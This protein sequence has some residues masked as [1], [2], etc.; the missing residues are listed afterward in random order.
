MNDPR[1]HAW[2]AEVE[3][4]YRPSDELTLQASGGWL[5]SRVDA[6]TVA[7]DPILG[8]EFGAAPRF[9]GTLA[10]D[11]LPLRN[12][13]LSSQIR[14]NSRYFSDDSATK[15]TQIQ[16]ST[17]VDARVSWKTGRFTIFGYAH[18]LFDEFHVTFWGGLPTDPGVEVGTNDPR[19]LG[20]GVDE[21]F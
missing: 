11:W 6:T 4:E 15:A 12:L 2:G 3:L 10:V 13:R 9:T 14:H 17:D 18:N 16:P 8:K 7:N 5:R 20:V 21:R 1:A 19:E